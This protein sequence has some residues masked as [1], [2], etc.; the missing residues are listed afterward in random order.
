MLRP[1]LLDVPKLVYEFDS[2]HMNSGY[3]Y[4]AMARAFRGVGA[5]FVSMFS[6][7][8]LDTAPYNL[9]W[10]T[11]F[12]NLVYSPKKAVSAI[13]AA[14]VTRTLPRYSSYGEYPDNCRFGPFRVSYEENSSQM[15]A[16]EKFTY[17]NETKDEAASPGRRCVTSWASRVRP[18][19]NTRAPAAISWTVC[20]RASGG[21][22]FIPM[23]FSCVIHFRK[24]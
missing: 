4:P 7:D 8:M 23:P 11:H 13:I 20:Y 6:Y 2:A 16:D 3:M 19:F 1:D 17:A 15:V 14:E 22:K 9:G 18:W 5:Q 21:S 10:Q 12:S 24:D